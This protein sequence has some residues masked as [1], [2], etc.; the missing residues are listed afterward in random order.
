MADLHYRLTPDIAQLLRAAN[1]TAAEW[2]LWSYLA[3]LDPFGD[4]Y[5]EMPDLVEILE[6]IESSCI[7]AHDQG[8]RPFILAKLSHLW[9]HGWHDLIEDLCQI[10][11]T[12]GIAAT[13]GGVLEA[14]G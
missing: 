12:W 7:A 13:N 9:Q 3:T 1:L 4:R 8:D 11:P 2:R 6:Q 10:Y 14:I 5:Q